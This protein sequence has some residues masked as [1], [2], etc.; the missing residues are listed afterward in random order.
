MLM[1]VHLV[2]AQPFPAAGGGGGIGFGFGC[3]EDENINNLYILF[4]L[5]IMQ[6]T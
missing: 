1:S 4:F 5:I 2:Q 3:F 6:A